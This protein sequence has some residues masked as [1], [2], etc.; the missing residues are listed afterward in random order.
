MSTR[1]PL[2][3]IAVG[4]V[5]MIGMIVVEDEPGGIPLLLIVCGIAWYFIARAR[6]GR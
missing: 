4:L 5:M 3:A 2:I 6:A 1:W